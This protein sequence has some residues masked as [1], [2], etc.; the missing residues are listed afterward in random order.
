V[1]I[2]PGKYVFFSVVTQAEYQQVIL[3]KD[4]AGH[5]LISAAGMG[6]GGD[7]PTQIDAGTF[8]AQDQSGNY[9]MS[10]TGNSQPSQVIWD[11]LPLTV[12]QTVMSTTYVF[13][14]EDGVDADFNDTCVTLTWF[15]QAG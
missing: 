7:P 8:L 14:S 10:I 1:F 12:G 3:L 9:T 5:A 4:S 15:D 13:N 6:T 11:Q 2:P